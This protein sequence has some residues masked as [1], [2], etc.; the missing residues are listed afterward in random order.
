LYQELSKKIVEVPQIVEKVVDRI[1]ESTQVIEVEKIV[2]VPMFE[3]RVKIVEVPVN[4]Y[5]T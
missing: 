1:I 2:Q 4:T 5:I 3:E